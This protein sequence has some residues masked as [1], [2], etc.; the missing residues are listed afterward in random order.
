VIDPSRGQV[1]ATID[2]SQLAVDAIGVPDDDVMVLN[3]IARLDG[4]M[5][6]LTGKEW[7]TMYR[8]RF[9]AP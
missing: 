1:V 5:F 9:V 4:D 2:A 6:L 3:G 8:V 7:P